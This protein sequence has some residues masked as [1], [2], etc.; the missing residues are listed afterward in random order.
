MNTADLQS[1]AARIFAAHAS[2]ETLSPITDRAALTLDDAYAIQRLLTQARLNRGEHVIGWKLGYMSSAM[3]L[4]MGV[5]SPNFG[6]L[7]SA[8]LLL[9]GSGVPDT[10]TQPRVEPEIA[11]RFERDVPSGADREAVL[12]CVGSAH[13]SLE[14]VDSV[15]FDYRFTLQ[16]NTADGSSAAGVVMGPALPLETIEHAQVAMWVDGEPAGSGVGSD[17]GG[18]PAV[19][20]VWLVQQLTEMG[21]RLRAG[22]IVLTGGITR[23]APLKTGS[24]ITARFNP[25]DLELS[26]RKD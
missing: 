20:V 21:L 1:E 10:M 18:H 3:R 24:V 15:W 22:D 5:A 12:R 17:A 7:T 16:D 25:G 23:A 4:Q 11:L 19:G 2:R 13:A 14:I 6:P 26:I 8:M 9:S